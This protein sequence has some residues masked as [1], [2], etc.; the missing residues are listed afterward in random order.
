MEWKTT[1]RICEI[2]G[3]PFLRLRSWV[4]ICSRKCADRRYY[5]KNRQE[6]IKKTKKWTKN[7]AGKVR[8]N[9]KKHKLRKRNPD[10]FKELMKGNYLRNRYKWYERSFVNK[11]REEIILIIGGKCLKCNEKAEVIHHI[12][13]KGIKRYHKNIKKYCEFLKPF[14][15]KHHLEEE[16]F[17]KSQRKN[18]TEL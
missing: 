9:K 4:T 13:Y 11:H 5:L 18:I 6:I 14:C 7:N 15:Y 16:A 2:C 10:R 3:K 17:K 12:K 1:N 8:E